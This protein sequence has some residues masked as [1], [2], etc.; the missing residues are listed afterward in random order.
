MIT[1]FYLP[2]QRLL[3]LVVECLVVV[4]DR[5]PPDDD[6]LLSLS[7]LLEAIGAADDDDDD[8]SG[9]DNNWE[10]FLFS[11]EGEE[12]SI[13]SRVFIDSFLD[14]LYFIEPEK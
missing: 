3:F 8:G 9:N 11:T 13:N 7:A 5:S 4:L 14:W 1:I 6:G 12:S 2:L 10:S